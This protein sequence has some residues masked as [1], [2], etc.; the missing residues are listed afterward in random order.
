[1]SIIMAGMYNNPLVAYKGLRLLLRAFS[2]LRRAAKKR[3][4]N[5]IKVMRN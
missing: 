3:Y 4:K 2:L 1:M 5:Y